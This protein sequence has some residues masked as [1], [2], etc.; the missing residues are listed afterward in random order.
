MLIR[1][2]KLKKK[3]K[4]KKGRL[5]IRLGGP[6]TMTPDE[7]KEQAVVPQP[8]YGG[9]GLVAEDGYHRSPSFAA[10]AIL[11]KLGDERIALDSRG[12]GSAGMSSGSR[13]RGLELRGARAQRALRKR[14]PCGK[15]KGRRRRAR[16]HFARAHWPTTATCFQHTKRW[17]L[18]RTP[19][20]GASIQILTKGLVSFNPPK[21]RDL[22]NES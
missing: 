3:K 5:S 20:A 15:F 19:H 2:V 4:K 12:H 1:W 7:K 13:D 21:S 6:K 16:S 11:H 22:P 17:T 14:L 10:F 18:R 8:F 9:F